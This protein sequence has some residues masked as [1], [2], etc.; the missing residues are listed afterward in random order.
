MSLWLDVVWSYQGDILTAYF[1]GTRLETVVADPDATLDSPTIAPDG[2]RL[3]L[4]RRTG[5]GTEVCAY[6]AAG[7]RCVDAPGLT[8]GLD[9]AK[10]SLTL[11][12][13]VREGTGEIWRVDFGTAI[14]V[15]E[16]FVGTD[17]YRTIG[18]SFSADGERLVMAQDPSIVTASFVEIYDMQSGTATVI[19]PDDGHA[20]RFP[21]PDRVPPFTTSQRYASLL[22][23]IKWRL[24][25]TLVY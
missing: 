19:V 15:A 16:L 5:I 7:L 9:W 18:L 12:F 2:N 8:A 3:G 13:T 1:D 10:D 21:L 14:P 17:S 20:D 24:N 11:Y 4:A 6:D 25:L 23:S 22:I